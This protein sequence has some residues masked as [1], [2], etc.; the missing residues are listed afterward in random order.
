MRESPLLSYK[1]LLIQNLINLPGWHTN[2][3]IVVFES[4]DWGTIRMPSLNVY[5]SL[6]TAGIRVDNLAYNK[7]DSLASEED[8]TSLIE[9]L[10]GIKDNYGNYP[11]FTLNTVVGNPDFE[12]I[13][14]SKFKEYFFEP[15][16]ETLKRYPKHNNSFKF[17][18]Q[19][20]KAGVFKP[21]FHGREHL[22]VNRWLRALQANNKDVRMAFNLGIFDLSIEQKI[23]ENS[24]MDA[25]NF[26]TKEEIAILKQSLS[27]GLD[28]FYSLFG[29]KS[30][31]FVAPS[32][33]WPCEIEGT[34]H[35]K[36]VRFI[37]S[38]QNQL[39][40]LAGTAHAFRKVFHYTGQRSKDGLYFIVRNSSFE[41]SEKPDYDWIGDL[42]AKAK[43]V[44]LWKKPLV[45]SSH[46]VNYIGFIDPVNRDKNLAKLS[47]LLKTLLN[48]WPDI[49]FLSTDQLG[50][51]INKEKQ[52][53]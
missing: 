34:L 8:L 11:V 49:E 6:L 43:S 16:T 45:I 48:E 42:L 13:Y 47:L 10:T 33:I 28:L 30:Q 40:P 2:R 19:G 18:E 50:E 37:Q 29:Y 9:T 27:E 51:L 32:Y 4:D 23:T 14:N 31:S 39:E 5:N 44:F 15:F 7:Y 36:G 3:K 52:L 12:K 17:W 21:Q 22:N 35:E 20:I 26:E 38:T 46:R 24:F 41:P 1:E 53:I 25:L